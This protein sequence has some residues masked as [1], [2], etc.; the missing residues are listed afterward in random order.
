MARKQ[1]T[2]KKRIK[3]MTTLFLVGVAFLTLRLFYIQFIKGGEYKRL[4]AQ[5]QTRDSVITA[6]RGTI[7]DRNMKILAQSASAERVTAN[8]QEISNNKKTDI[9]VAGLVS[10]LGVSEKSVRKKLEQTELQSVIIAR[11]VEKS[12][13]DE[14]RKKKLT[15]V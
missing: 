7:Y 15:G 14:L 12:V 1:M 6:K 10:T 8:P 11:Q 4:A 13:A 3:T 5:Q 9:V 2:A